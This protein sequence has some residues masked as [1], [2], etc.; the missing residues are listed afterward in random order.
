M[1]MIDRLRAWTYAR[2]QLA[3][4]A[5][6]PLKALDAVVGVYAT[7][8]TAPLA[9]R[10]RCRSFTPAAY[11]RLDR[12]GKALRLPCMRQTVFLVSRKKAAR[13]F[14]AV[15]PSAAHAARAL[16]RQKISPQT[17]KKLT[18][19]IIRAAR[20]P[21]SSSELG[22]EV[23][24]KGE[25]LTAV[26]RCLRYEGRLVNIAGDSLLSSP[27]TYV[28]TKALEPDG[29]DEGD[30]EKALAWL[31]GEYLRAYGPARVE[32]FAWW[33]GVTKTKART[34]IAT[35]ETVDVDEGLLLLDRD[36]ARFDGT[37]RLRNAIA[38]LPRW[39]SYTMGHAPHGRQ[40]FVHPDMQ[41]RVYTPIGTGLPGDGNPVVLIDG[42]V[43]A[44]WTYS[45]KEGIEVRPF[46]TIGPRIR[47]R[48]D[49][50]LE[51]IPVLLSS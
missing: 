28:A 21:V 14:T 30:A 37:R 4:P 10:A 11:R 38:V 44:V 29:L 27:H 42:Q 12:D 24:I 47:R 16:K 1:E 18:E 39:D 33:A 45:K 8:P 22:A 26:V 2:Q 40:R 6:T 35:L 15:R 13:V 49:A 5:S 34:A 41:D 43:A 7:H 31:A 50:E 25:K 17:Y 46:D 32:D 51:A 20:E 48:I 3:E 23:G 36:E 19:T 9:L